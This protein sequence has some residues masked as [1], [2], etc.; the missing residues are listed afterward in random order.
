MAV[1]VLSGGKAKHQERQ[2]ALGRLG[3]D[4]ARRARSKCELCTGA[5]AKLFE[6]NPDA[7]EPS[8]E[9]V[10]LL[11]ERCTELVRRDCKGSDERELRFLSEVVWAE[12][13]VVA[14]TAKSL[15][16]T[17]GKNGTPWAEEALEMLGE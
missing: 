16:R 8:L 14:D 15:L 4:L 1:Q 17:L 10:L 11:C 13:P 2:E 5:G 6:T 9:E 12:T 7:R 3:K